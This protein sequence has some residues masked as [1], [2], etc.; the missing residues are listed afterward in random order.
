MI[1][2]GTLL[3]EWE[4]VRL[5]TQ[6]GQITQSVFPRKNTKPQI[7]ADEHRYIILSDFADFPIIVVIPLTESGK[8]T[9]R[10]ERKVRKAAQ[11]AP[12]WFFSFFALAHEWA[13]QSGF[14][15]RLTGVGDELGS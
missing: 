2:M 7:N 9:H 13:Q 4:V 10:K 3:E 5:W 12:L 14:H 8:T 15:L 11:H 1:D 6:K